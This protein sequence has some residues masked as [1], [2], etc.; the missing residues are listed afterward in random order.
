MTVPLQT[1]WV[2][3]SD[4][5]SIHLTEEEI[6]IIGAGAVS[7]RSKMRS[8]ACCSPPH[9]LVAQNEDYNLVDSNR[10]ENVSWLWDKA[11][12][13]MRQRIS[14]CSVTRSL[15]WATEGELEKGLGKT[16]RN[17]H[18]HQV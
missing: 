12:R 6:I 10:K 18:A 14:I 3:S 15:V 8:R 1:H 13:S 11:T 2:I 4:S 7:R 5:I 9:G 17:S 16:T